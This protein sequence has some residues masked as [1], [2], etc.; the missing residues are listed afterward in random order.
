MQEFTE[1]KDGESMRAD[2]SGGMSDSRSL[3]SHPLA[4]PEIE[5]GMS[6]FLDIGEA[7]WR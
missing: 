1:I 2:R 6:D 4:I 3:K 5:G 7:D